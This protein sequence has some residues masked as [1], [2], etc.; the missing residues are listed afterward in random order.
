MFPAKR[1]R[2]LHFKAV[3]P[4]VAQHR[5][6]DWQQPGKCPKCGYFLECNAVF[7]AGIDPPPFCGNEAFTCSHPSRE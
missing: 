1:F 4:V 7:G 6:K 5:V 2:W 3:C